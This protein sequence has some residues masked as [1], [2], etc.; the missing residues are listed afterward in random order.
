ML[1]WEFI[2]HCLLLFLPLFAFGLWGYPR[3][4]RQYGGGSVVG[5]YYR[6]LSGRKSADDTP[7]II[8]TKMAIFAIW[9]VVVGSL[10]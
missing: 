8:A 9:F 6:S 3:W 1:S 10:I 2:G 4:R 5:Y 7:P